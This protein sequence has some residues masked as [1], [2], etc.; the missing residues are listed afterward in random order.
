MGDAKI[1]AGQKDAFT[2]FVQE[3]KYLMPT[4]WKSKSFSSPLSFGGEDQGEGRR[5]Q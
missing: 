1:V 5:V 3:A 2:K 4:H